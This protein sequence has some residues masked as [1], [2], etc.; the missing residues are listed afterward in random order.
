VHALHTDSQRKNGA[1]KKRP[2]QWRVTF[3]YSKQKISM[4]ASKG[5]LVGFST[6]KSEREY[7]ILGVEMGMRQVKGHFVGFRAE[8]LRVLLCC[9]CD[10]IERSIAPI[11]HGKAID[12]LWC[13]P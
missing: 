2:N 10:Y 1:K 3:F 11:Y 5:M 12:A 6:S 13:A 9:N 4:N 8:T 7:T